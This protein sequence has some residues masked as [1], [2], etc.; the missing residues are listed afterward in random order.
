MD[1]ATVFAGVQALGTLVA[2][3]AVAVTLWGSRQDQAIARAAMQQDQRN[4]EAQALRTEAA[5][6][7]TEE[8]TRR[9]V[10]ALERVASQGL[11]GGPAVRPKVAWSLVHGGGD[12]YRLTN[13]GDLTA[14]AVMVNTH[15]TLQ[16]FGFEGAG[17]DVRPGEA[18]TFYAAPDMGTEDMTVTVAWTDSESAEPVQ[19]WRYPLPYGR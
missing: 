4:A 6:G 17:P 5:A 9:V 13:E 2:L 18:M 16:V 7:L 8:Y 19:T 15:K 1:A 12:L 3:V 10:D 11:G 14:E